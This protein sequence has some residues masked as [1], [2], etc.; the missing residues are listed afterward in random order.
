MPLAPRNGNLLAVYGTKGSWDGH[1]SAKAPFP[2]Q[3]GLTEASEPRIWA[4]YWPSDGGR[5]VLGGKEKHLTTS[6]RVRVSSLFQEAVWLS[7]QVSVVLVRIVHRNMRGECQ[8]KQQN[9]HTDVPHAFSPWPNTTNG[10]MTSGP[11]SRAA[12]RPGR[13]GRHATVRA[14][15]LLASRALH[16]FNT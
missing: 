3:R 12:G 5:R 10:T 13:V 14:R 4:R 16:C 2:R 11:R 8:S 7:G 15:I 9:L 1:V 6:T